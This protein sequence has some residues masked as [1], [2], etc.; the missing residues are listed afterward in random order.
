M[1][2]QLLSKPSFNICILGLLLSC[3][4]YAQEYSP[5]NFEQGVWI[6]EGFSKP[7]YN[8]SQ[9][10]CQ[11]DTL[12]E[13]YIYN[14]L[15]EFGLQET[16]T[17]Y[18]TVPSHYI[19]AVRE[20]DNKQVMFWGISDTAFT[21]IYDFNLSIGD[22]ISMENEV[23][24]AESIDSV[25]I[26]GRYHKRYVQRIFNGQ[27]SETLIEGVGYSGGFLGY[28][29]GFP[30]G[31]FESY[32]RLKCYTEWDN[33]LCLDCKL[34][35]VTNDRTR[36]SYIQVYPNPVTRGQ[37]VHITFNQPLK[38]PRIEIYNTLGQQVDMCIPEE[39]VQIDAPD[40]VGLYFVRVVDGDVLVESS[41]LIV[42]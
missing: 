24:I 38:Y 41:K 12:L 36:T 4:S 32:L 8:Y 18:D 5:M 19:G 26:C 28:F 2:P 30:G 29:W 6:E 34:L 25:E 16:M 33:Q 7:F 15:Y 14:K 3:I 35:L 1:I 31:A 22:T 9:I 42:Q 23:F 39:D 37:S 27:F 21:V 11:G 17:R 10:Y 20:N 13:G 40:R